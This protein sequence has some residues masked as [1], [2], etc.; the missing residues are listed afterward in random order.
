MSP[1]LAKIVRRSSAGIAVL[2]LGVA[3]VVL[4]A[5]PRR[6][7]PVLGPLAFPSNFAAGVL[8]G[9]VDRADRNEFRELY[10]PAAAL[11]AIRAAR[12]LPRG[13]VLTMVNYAAERDWLGKPITDERGRFI[14]GEMNAI[15]VMEKRRDAPAHRPSDAGAAN[16]RFQM[17]R[18]DTTI[19][20][21]ANLRD[22]AECHE[23][24]RSQDYIFTGDMMKGGPPAVR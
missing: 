9:T 7:E 21:R 4:D 18:P 2:A 16:W 22:C 12:P 23:K 20:D 6:E 19:E 24:R 1:R 3:A 15:L 17:F 10:A 8:Y 14:K 11:A 13:T 5:A